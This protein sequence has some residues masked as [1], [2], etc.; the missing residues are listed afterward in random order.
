MAAYCSDPQPMSVSFLVSPRF[1]IAACFSV[2]TLQ[3][4][5]IKLHLPEKLFWVY[6][7]CQLNAKWSIQVKD[8]L[9]C[10]SAFSPIILS[11]AGTNCRKSF[12]ILVFCLP[13][14]L[15]GQHE[16]CAES[17]HN[18]SAT[19]L[20]ECW[21]CFWN[22]ASSQLYFSLTWIRLCAGNLPWGFVL[23]RITRRLLKLLR[24]G[25]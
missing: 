7:T 6:V 3:R 12:L 11:L 9:L 4:A 20:Y 24:V 8:P 10:S 25:H 18:A 13:M 1:Y 22:E 15:K 2:L 23:A 19:C 17:S 16:L 5:I 21:W 14:V